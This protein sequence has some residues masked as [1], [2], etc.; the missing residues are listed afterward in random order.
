MKKHLLVT[1]A[2][3]AV[4][5]MTAPV[6]ADTYMT[7]FGGF[8]HIKD[9]SATIFQTSG[10]SSSGTAGLLLT[11]SS[12]FHNHGSPTFANHWTATQKYLTSSFNSNWNTTLSADYDFDVG[13]VIGAAMGWDLK[14]YPCYSLELEVAYRKND[15]DANVQYTKAWASS[16]EGTKYLQVQTWYHWT[17][18]AGV[19]KDSNTF[20]FT[21]VLATTFDSTAST[22]AGGYTSNEALSGDLTSWS[23]MANVWYDFGYRGDIHP[24]IGGGI[25]FADVELDLGDVSAS[26]N[27][28]AWQAGVGI[29]FDL[30]ER[31]RLNLEYRY[32]VV[33][34]VELT[35]DGMDLGIDYEVN[36]ILVGL[37]FSF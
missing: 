14:K 34:D 9:Q 23:V 6:Q 1:T 37:K 28:F 32:F 35:F 21:T 11:S 18:L 25:G 15:V 10:S 36:E 3:G 7:V 24:Y 27:G 30:T 12:Y 19:T 20:G 2:T 22:K 33:P 29:G 31:T 17:K 16:F 26:D 8:S 13:F 5:A 4:M